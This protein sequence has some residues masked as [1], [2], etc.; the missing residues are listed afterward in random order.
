MSTQL[1]E[2]AL[3]SLRPLDQEI[4]ALRHFQELSNEEA[5]TALEIEPSVAGKLYF[6]AMK[7]LT[8]RMKNP[9]ASSFQPFSASTSAFQLALS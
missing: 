6:R 7:R 8:E 9:D 4:L 5:A 2:N 3:N 1:L